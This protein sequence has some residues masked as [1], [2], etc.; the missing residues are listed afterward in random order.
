[1]PPSLSAGAGLALL[2]ALSIFAASPATAAA[3]Q[4][5]PTIVLVHGAFADGSSWSGVIDALQRQGYH[6]TAVQNPLTSLAADVAATRRVLQRQRGDVLLVGHSWGG[7]V[8][9]EA[10]NADNVKGIVYLSALVPDT[11]ESVGTLLARL[12]APM[13]GLQP[14]TQGL[15]WLDDAPTYQ[16][17]MAADV[18]LGKVRQLAAVQQPMTA[19]AFDDTITQAAWHRK[20]SWYLI[21][22][23]NNAL[24]P[25]VQRA[26]AKQIGATTSTIASSHLSPV[27]QPT[28]V[29]EFI[30]HAARS[31]GTPSQ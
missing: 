4:G 9:T 16:H 22:D 31:I 14:D 3:K 23:N 5:R 11:G 6:V 13:E 2:S 15:V 28:K 27:A 8:V 12:K 21:T 19:A 17:V 18:P 29:A 1:M 20:P 7:A 24:R 25:D 26:I 30:A 10:G